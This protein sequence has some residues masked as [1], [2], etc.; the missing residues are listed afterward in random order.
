[1]L[2]H[3][4]NGGEPDEPVDRGAGAMKAE[5]SE[6]GVCVTTGGVTARPVTAQVD[7]LALTAASGEALAAAWRDCCTTVGFER[8]E[9]MRLVT[10]AV[11][12]RGLLMPAAAPIA[13]GLYSA[14][15]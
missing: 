11:S 14:V 12:A 9:L 7:K 10:A 5:K 8:A 2:A 6:I 15:K 4:V 3:S 13:S 1:M